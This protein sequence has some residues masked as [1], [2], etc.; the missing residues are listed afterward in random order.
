MILAGRD[1]FTL[2]TFSSEP[3][4]SL[5]PS[6]SPTRT[7][8]IPGF[9]VALPTSFHIAMSRV[10]KPRGRSEAGRLH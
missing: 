4:F 2:Q 6:C 9:K 3:D 10:F 5:R 8:P 1:D 7:L